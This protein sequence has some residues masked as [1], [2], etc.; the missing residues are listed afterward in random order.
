[1]NRILSAFD[2]GGV[3]LAVVIDIGYRAFGARKVYQVGGGGQAEV[4]LVKAFPV[5]GNDAHTAFQIFVLTGAPYQ[6]SKLFL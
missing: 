4:Y 3:L 2:G 1:M 6:T 5:D